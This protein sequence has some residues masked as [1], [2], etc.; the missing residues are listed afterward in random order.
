MA[1]A[2]EAAFY[3]LS[4][5]HLERKTNEAI[6]AEVARGQSLAVDLKGN[7]GG[8][9]TQFGIFAA[10]G[11]DGAR[12]NIVLFDTKPGSAGA[13]EAFGRDGHETVA[14][15]TEMATGVKLNDQQI[16]AAEKD[17]SDNFMPA[18]KSIED[19]VRKSL[20][21]HGVKA[22]SDMKISVRY[23]YGQSVGVHLDYLQSMKDTEVGVGKMLRGIK[24]GLTVG[25][26]AALLMNSMS[27]LT[28]VS[29]MQGQ[30][31]AQTLASWSGEVGKML[32]FEK[33]RGA[34]ILTEDG[35]ITRALLGTGIAD[36]SF[37]RDLEGLSSGGQSTKLPF[38]RGW[39]LYWDARTS[40]YKQVDAVPKMALAR[41]QMKALL[42]DLG[43]L[44][45]GKT[46]SLD[47]GAG[48]R[49]LIYRD[50][51]G[52][53]RLNGKIVEQSKIDDVV[54]KQATRASA[55]ALFDFNESGILFKAAFKGGKPGIVNELGSWFAKAL[56]MPGRQG[57]F[58]TA[59]M[60]DPKTSYLTNDPSLLAGKAAAFTKLMVRRTALHASTR[61]VRDENE[62]LLGQTFGY[63]RGPMTMTT[64]HADDDS[65]YDVNVADMSSSSWMEAGLLQAESAA[66]GAGHIRDLLMDKLGAF[67]ERGKE[68]ADIIERAGHRNNPGR[69][70]LDYQGLTPKEKQAAQILD[71]HIGEIVH[72][73]TGDRDFI[74]SI[75]SMAQA[76]GG[77][78]GRAIKLNDMTAAKGGEFILQMF[79]GRDIATLLT[80]PGVKRADPDNRNSLKATNRDESS[81]RFALSGFF[82]V[83]GR[84]KN[85]ETAISSRLNHLKREVSLRY[86]E[87]DIDEA[88]K[89]FVFWVLD[90]EAEKAREAV[91]AIREGR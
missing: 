73:A 60:F 27:N 2:A 4:Q 59:A 16:T 70:Y 56:E 65:G 55:A 43:K 49:A 31:T 22:P 41:A 24:R 34:S 17:L 39:D 44:G 33:N 80:Q 19:A 86:G 87:G 61:A 83:I 57:I 29:V 58:S 79:A 78:F 35:R 72:R 26:T 36:S 88:T 82:R 46:M 30:T 20:A 9:L 53:L 7:I 6:G 38:Q 14:K 13:V 51:A 84:E 90:G 8:P 15:T 69:R 48:N 40:A 42:G 12:P 64:R 74:G 47:I 68:A 52:Q 28:L 77:L 23:G 21:E 5:Q 3:S 45:N 63:S 91:K 89:T 54:A 71:R 81:M 37:A 18:P 62:R 11:S 66:A 10:A 1:G 75:L 67:S 25:S 32:D 50:N 85:S 76:T